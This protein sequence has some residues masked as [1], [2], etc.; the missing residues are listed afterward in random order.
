MNKFALR[1]AI[2][3]LALLLV[4]CTNPASSGNNS[5]GPTGGYLTGT[6][7]VTFDFRVV[8]DVGAIDV[9]YIVVPLNIVN[10]WEFGVPNPHS[11]S[12]T[13][14]FDG[15]GDALAAGLT[16]TVN[17]GLASATITITIDG[18]LVKTLTTQSVSNFSMLANGN[19]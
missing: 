7:T 3:G 16:S 10:V 4:T 12:Y 13:V 2:A 6:H 9:N 17:T 19:F 1:T 11:K 14:T 8:G 18:K 5:N 15:R